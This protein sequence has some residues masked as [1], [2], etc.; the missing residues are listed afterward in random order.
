M[1]MLRTRSSTEVYRDFAV[2]CGKVGCAKQPY[3]PLIKNACYNYLFHL[4][5]ALWRIW[6]QSWACVFKPVTILCA[7]FNS[8]L[9]V[10]KLHS[11]KIFWL[12][13]MPVTFGFEYERA[14]FRKHQY[15][16]K[17]HNAIYYGIIIISE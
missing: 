2:E 3:S 12:Q 15:G 11:N 9:N 4:L 13:L 5:I 8:P 16:L 7:T 10:I 17:I 14:S 1:N 6:N